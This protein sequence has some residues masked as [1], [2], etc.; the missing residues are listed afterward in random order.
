[1]RKIAG[2]NGVPRSIIDYYFSQGIPGEVVS[3]REST[4]VKDEV[5]YISI[6]FKDHPFR[7]R[8]NDGGKAGTYAIWKADIWILERIPL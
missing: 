4:S 7:H 6:Q 1:M 2:M 5:A 3:C 8:W